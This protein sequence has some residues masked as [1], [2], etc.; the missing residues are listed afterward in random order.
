MKKAAVIGYPIAQ[1]LS[2]VIHNHWFEQN[3]IEGNYE[4]IE[5]VPEEL[6]MAVERLKTEG[7]SGFNVTVPHKTDII[8]YLDKVAPLARQMGAVNTVKIAEDGTLSGFNTDGIGLV[9]H[10]KDIVPEYPKDKPALI[11]GA[12]GAARAAA[13]GLVNENLPMVMI[14]NRT[15]GKA[16]AIAGDVGRGRMTVVDWKTRAQAVA[17]AGLIVNTTVLGMAGQPALELS[18]DHAASDTVVYDIVYKPLE[19]ELL[20]DA[21]ERGL[22]TVDGLGMLVHQGAAAFKIWFGVEVGFDADL[23]KTLEAKIT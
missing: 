20:K 6:G 13:L 14:T 9:K 15:R 11:I 5:V 12:G 10:L 22:K 2:P 18:L 8:K 7:Y 3:G 17:A 1:S 4:A 23:R 19:T 21:G 16:E